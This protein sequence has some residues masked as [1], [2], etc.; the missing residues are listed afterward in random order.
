M[1]WVHC[2]LERKGHSQTGSG[3]PWKVVGIGFHAGFGKSGQG[4]CFILRVFA[5]ICEHIFLPT[6]V[7]LSGGKEWY[8]GHFDILLAC[9][10][11][12]CPKL[13]PA[14]VVLL[15]STSCSAKSI[16]LHT[17]PRVVGL[18]RCES[19]FIQKGLLELARWLCREVSHQMR[20][21]D[22]ER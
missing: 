7:S 21:W 13:E 10:T 5:V 11:E 12:L 16:T 22:S 4:R 1:I 2:S 9:G 8:L 19:V 6:T 15:Y 3:T 17:T 20:G 18:G 14:M